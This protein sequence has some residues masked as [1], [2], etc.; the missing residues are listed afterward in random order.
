MFFN[1]IKDI[2]DRALYLFTIAA[3][4]YLAPA[5]VPGHYALSCASTV[6][7]I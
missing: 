6:M 3:C 4:R 1:G 2:A 5:E 7:F